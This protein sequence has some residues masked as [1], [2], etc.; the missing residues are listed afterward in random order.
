MHSKHSCKIFCSYYRSFRL[1]ITNQPKNLLCRLC[2]ITSQIQNSK[3]LQTRYVPCMPS[4]LLDQEQALK[5]HLSMIKA[6]CYLFLPCCRSLD[7]LQQA[8]SSFAS[9]SSD[10]SQLQAR[11]DS[12]LVFYSVIFARS[13]MELVIFTAQRCRQSNIK[14]SYYFIIHQHL[15]IF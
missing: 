6:Y 7:A 2:S 3:H 8:S 5:G 4:L 12:Q 1:L 10:W 11:W 15:C 9:V 14:D 13:D